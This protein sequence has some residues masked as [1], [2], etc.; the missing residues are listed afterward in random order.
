[1]SEFFDFYNM[2]Y[3]CGYLTID[4]LKGAVAAGVL[5]TDDFLKITGQTYTP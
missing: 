4:D 2:F 1:M 3:T 5:T